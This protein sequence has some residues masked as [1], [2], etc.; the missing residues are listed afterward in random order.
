MYDKYHS[1]CNKQTNHVQLH[2][3]FWHWKT[4][5]LPFSLCIMSLF[6]PMKSFFINK[7][8]VGFSRD[9]WHWAF[10]GM[11]DGS[12][13]IISTTG[14]SYGIKRHGEVLLCQQNQPWYQWKC[15]CPNHR[16]LA[17]KWGLIIS[18]IIIITILSNEPF[19]L[20]WNGPLCS[21]VVCWQML[22][23]WLLRENSSLMAL[24]IFMMHILYS[25]LI[26][27]YQCEFTE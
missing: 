23:N 21:L 15:H 3:N 24:T 10:P 20:L 5:F 18:N 7:S 2:E 25:W 4:Y 6:V 16:A 13:E 8:L 9:T 22:T 17:S 12:P 1:L 27:S 26:L 19:T 11:K 14:H